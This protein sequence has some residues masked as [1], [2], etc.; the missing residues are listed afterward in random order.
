MVLK[1]SKYIKIKHSHLI[2]I[3]KWISNVVKT[4]LQ[5]F[6]YLFKSNNSEL[7]HHFGFFT[8]IQQEYKANM[9]VRL[10]HKYKSVYYK[11]LNCKFCSKWNRMLFKNQN[12]LIFKSKSNSIC[13]LKITF[14][15]YWQIKKYSEFQTE[16]KYVCALQK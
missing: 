2:K 6:E 4:I 1:L 15:N 12:P 9:F 13:L 16:W 3:I 5:G 7:S 14:Y 11:H 10:N 8:Q